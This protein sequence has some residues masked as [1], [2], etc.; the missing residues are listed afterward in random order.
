MVFRKFAIPLVSIFCLIVSSI[1][2]FGLSEAEKTFLAMYFSD[3]ELVV[4]SATRSL[5][6][7]TRVAENVSIVT[8]EDIELM[9][10]HTVADV[11]RTINGV[12]LW[13]AGSGVG[14]NNAA[15]IQGSGQDHVAVFIDGM[16]FNNPLFNSAEFHK[17]PVQFIDRIE[18][19]KGPA[20]SSWGSSLGGVINLITK[21]AWSKEG[22]SGMVSASLGEK[23]T[24]DYRAELQGGKG[25]FGYYLTAGRF[26]TD[27]FN[28]DDNASSKN[29]YTKIGYKPG[30]D[31]TVE[32]SLLYNREHGGRGQFLFWDLDSKDK[33]E[34]ILS[35]LSL[36][37][38][39]SSELELD[40]ALRYMRHRNDYV[41][42]L[43]ST[44]EETYHPIEDIKKYG[45]G[46]KLIWKRGVHTL[47]AG[48]DLLQ[49]KSS[50]S[51]LAEEAIRTTR[52]A[53]FANDTISLGALTIIPGLRYDDTTR[54]KSFL[55]PSIGLTYALTS[56][57]LLR[58]YVA[59]GFNDPSAF[60]LAGHSSVFEPNP[61][62]KPEN[63]W[64]YQAGVET[65]ILKTFWLKV[66]AFNHEIKDIVVAQDV[67]D[68]DG[69]WTY[70]NLGRARRYGIEVEIKT[71]PIYNFTLSAGGSAIRAK[72][73]DTGEMIIGAPKATVNV[74]LAYDDKRSL[75][76]LLTASHIMYNQ[77]SSLG[78]KYN[79]TVFDLNIIKKLYRKGDLGLESFATGHNLFNAS[80][81]WANPFFNARRWFEAGMRLR[82]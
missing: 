52:Y 7:I 68:S 55:S 23:N 33:K 69:K 48:A 73:L 64:S 53:Y 45:A 13:T 20:S 27:G 65:G 51:V 31:T 17:V 15:S 25:P 70:V 77:D 40:A 2:A 22:I 8:K 21:S 24:G 16:L 56:D 29:L 10:A 76:A 12:Q 63:V 59:R 82:F 6:S 47:V 37:S 9:N 67:P 34:T 62:L 46:A 57:V 60:S 32:F 5:K 36:R 44:G 80:Q 78:G 72:D 66:A 19:I 30:K 50:D 75:R 42:S 58:G 71:I 61:G 1:N 43:V 79:S 3:E 28:P 14:S 81:Y 4:V 38:S 11:L 49:D 74:S 26:R 35:T 39:L 54:T 18:V 41:E